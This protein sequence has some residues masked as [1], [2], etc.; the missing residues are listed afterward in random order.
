MA[1]NQAAQVACFTV[2]SDAPPC[3]LKPLPHRSAHLAPFQG[4]YLTLRLGGEE[5]AIDI[6]RSRRSGHTKSPPTNNSPD[7]IKGV[8]ICAG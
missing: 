8:I 1:R 6:F 3:P 5:Y 4:Q 2:V 7:Y